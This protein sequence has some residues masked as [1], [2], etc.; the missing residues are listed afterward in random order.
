MMSNE[1]RKDPYTIAVLAEAASRGGRPVSKSHL[2]RLCREG[3]IPAEKDGRA[4]MIAPRDAEMWLIDW[5]N[6]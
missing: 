5:L 3:K 4:W 1:E 6:L 2:S